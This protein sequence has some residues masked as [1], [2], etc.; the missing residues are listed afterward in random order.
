MPIKEFQEKR[1]LPVI[2]KIR[3]GTRKTSQ[4]GKEYPSESEHFVLDDAPDV[5]AVYG[6][7]PKQLE[8][9]FPSDDLN[10]VI[11]HYYKW[12][13]GGVKD[14]E[15]NIIGGKLNCYGDGDVAHWLAKRDVATRVVPTRKCAAEQC[16]DWRDGKGVQQCKAAMSVYV[17]LPRVSLF[18]VYQIDTTSKSAIQ[19]FVNQMYLI[20]ETWG[21]FRK[22][23][24]IVYRDPTM[25]GFVDKDGKEQRREH[26]ILRIRP[27]E[28]FQQNH[29]VELQGRVQRLLQGSIVLPTEQQLIEA[30]M[31]DNYPAE[32]V[33]VEAAKPAAGIELVANDPE[34]MPLFDELC[35]LRK[36][37]NNEKMRLLTARKFENQANAK[38]AL[39]S[40]LVSEI[41]K[42]KPA[43]E[44]APAQADVPPT[45]AVSQPA[46]NADG[47]I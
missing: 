19:D 46:L 29:G 20:K 11:P 16:P 24:F 41:G 6:K 13:S 12:Y 40:Y 14:K 43:A 35:K 28:S 4:G 45:P 26:H 3:L 5:A 38:T 23:H 7:E 10:I 39:K 17:I 36:K 18:G 25:I 15:G 8:V 22:Q 32:V 33:A 27:D 47:L 42:A 2:G 37:T 44:A 21:T 34:L 30:P 1:R 9:M 31:E